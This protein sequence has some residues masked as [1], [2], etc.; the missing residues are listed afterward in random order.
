VTNY[1][2]ATVLR[3]VPTMMSDY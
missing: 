1:F 2:V 3:L